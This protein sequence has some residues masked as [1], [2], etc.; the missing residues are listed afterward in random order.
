MATV[1]QDNRTV[2]RNNAPTW[3]SPVPPSRTFPNAASSFPVNS[4]EKVA[5]SATLLNMIFTS[6]GPIGGSSNRDPDE[7]DAVECVRDD[8]AESGG[9]GGDTF[10]V[11]FPGHRSDKGSWT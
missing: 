6:S 9:V 10:S 4:S 2:S 3:S 7:S 1:E 5:R 11:V 8:D